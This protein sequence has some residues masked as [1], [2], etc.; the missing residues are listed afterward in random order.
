[1]ADDPSSKNLDVRR[2]TLLIGGSVGLAAVGL[3]LAGCSK[4]GRNPSPIRS[5]TREF[6]PGPSADDT[7]RPGGTLRVGV[8]GGGPNETLNP[9]V[10]V[11]IAD[12]VRLYNLFEPLFSAGPDGTLTPKLAVNAVSNPSADVWMFNLRRGVTWHN[13]KPFTADDVVFTIKNSWGAQTNYFNAALASVVD[14]RNV[15]RLDAYTVRIPLKLSVAEFSSVTAFPNLYIVQDGTKDFNNGIGTGPFSLTSFKPGTSS[16][17]ANKNYWDEGKPYVDELVVNSSFQTEESR[18]NALLSGDIDIVPQALPSLAAAN[19]SDGRV[20]LGHQPGPAMLPMIMRVDQGSLKDPKIRQA[21]KLLPDRDVFVSNV[22]NGYGATTNDAPGRTAKYWAEDLVQEQ[23]FDQAKSLLKAAGAEDA[24]FELR[25][26]IVVAGMNETATLFKQQAAEGGVKINLKQYAAANYYGAEAGVFDRD[27]C[28]DFA[29][30]GLNS[31]SLFY[32]TW[33]L[34]GAPY[35]QSFFGG[36][37]AATKQIL[38]AIGETDE[39][40]A[41]D[42]WHTVQ[43]GQVKDGPYIIP[44]GQ[45]WLDAYSPKVRGTQTTTAYTCNGYD[46]AS[47]WLET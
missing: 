16:F 33:M 28:L 3:G 22:Y 13:G 37:A 43:E 46:F 9:Q 11:G 5:V 2:R 47:G 34:P 17:A 20:V 15:E 7:P 14:F 23:D 38:D 24:T 21:L 42:K 44:A 45:N 25:T 1:M 8:F 12:N 6:S 27:F 35:N 18:F 10:A 36:D 39:T 29:A 32:L 26:S 40:A 19:A 30:Q 41:A 31:L 4:D